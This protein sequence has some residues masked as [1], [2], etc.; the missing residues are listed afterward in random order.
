MGDPK[1]TKVPTLPNTA[2]CLHPRQSFRPKLSKDPSGL[3][4]ICPGAPREGVTVGN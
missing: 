2:A 4:G 3:P 1:D